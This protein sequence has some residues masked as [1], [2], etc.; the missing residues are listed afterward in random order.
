MSSLLRALGVVAAVVAAGVVLTSVV[1]LALSAPSSAPAGDDPGLPGTPSVAQSPAP[2]PSATTTRPSP[3]LSPR[4]SPTASRTPAPRT[5]RT[6][7]TAPARP[8]TGITIALDPGHQLG[9]S[10]FPRET[11][12]LVPA[13][14]FDKPC[15]TTGTATDAGI[16]EATVNFELAQAVRQRLEGLGA[17][18]VLTRTTNSVQRWGPCVDAR[19]LLAA[20]AG[21]RLMVSLHADGAGAGDHGFHVIAPTSRAPWTDDIADP[22]LGLATALRD[23]LRAGSFTPANYGGLEAGLIQRDDLGTLNLSDVPVAM[24]EI[25]NMRN[26]GDAQ[27]MTSTQGQARYAAAVVRG[28]RTFLGDQPHAKG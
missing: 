13:G 25:G 27:Q 22:S 3:R 10:R 16:P 11:N 6:T 8:L 19:G 14:G 26:S 2:T 24:I 7:T 4:P 12:A 15:N 17:R 21:A 20:R 28:I 5:A 1:E 23:A 18:V 9:N